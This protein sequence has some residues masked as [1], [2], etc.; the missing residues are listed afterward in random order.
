MPAR[1]NARAA[2][3]PCLWAGCA[4]L[5]LILLSGCG[6]APPVSIQSDAIPPVLRIATNAAAAPGNPVTQADRGPWSPGQPDAPR[7]KRVLVSRLGI[8]AALDPLQLDAKQ[9]LVPPRYGRA[10]WYEDGPE[11][12]EPGRAVVA[13]HVDSKTGPDVFARLRE[14]R[15]G[16][17]IKVRLVD[18]TTLVYRVLKVGLFQQSSFPTDRVYGGSANRSEIRLITCG[19]AYDRVRGRYTANVIVFA[20]LLA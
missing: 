18:G 12:G 16:D 20:R 13:G 4:T 10:G 19:G 15:T 6:A 9:V 17:R 8:D 1:L 14:V 7:P 11:P 3:G 2:H 5:G